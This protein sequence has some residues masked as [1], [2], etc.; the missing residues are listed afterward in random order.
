[1][2]GSPGRQLRDFGAARK[3]PVT[4]RAYTAAVIQH[5]WALPVRYM[6]LDEPFGSWKRWQ[7]EPMLRCW[8]CILARFG[9]GF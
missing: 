3:C 1:M 6:V 8:F 4:I 9:R 7:D 2:P 5:H